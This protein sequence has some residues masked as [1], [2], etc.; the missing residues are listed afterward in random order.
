M[1]KTLIHDVIALTREGW[2][3]YRGT[4]NGSVYAALGC[5]YGLGSKKS[6][7]YWFVREDVFC[8]VGCGA[9]CTLS[10]PAGFPLPLPQPV[11]YFTQDTPYTLTPQEM[12]AKK[13]L[14]TVRQ[15]SYCLNVSERMV[16]DWI[17]EGRLVRLKD[18]PIRVRSDEVRKMMQDFDE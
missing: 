18:Q 8:C 3:P 17:A 10:R 6:R 1:S 4:P 14:L 5:E 2:R 9:R 15:A 12:V 7:P 13:S 16:Y 11:N